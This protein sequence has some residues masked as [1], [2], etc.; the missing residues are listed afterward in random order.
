MKD[1]ENQEEAGQVKIKFLVKKKKRE[2]LLL[3]LEA[4]KE[5]ARKMHDFSLNSENLT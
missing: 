3:E 4:T 1:N 5:K 2:N